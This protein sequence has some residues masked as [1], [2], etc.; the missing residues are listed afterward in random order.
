LTGGRLTLIG[1]AKP[2]GSATAMR[3]FLARH[4]SAEGYAG[5]TDFSVYRLAPSRGHYV[6]GFGR[7]VDLKPAAL[8]ASSTSN[9]RASSST[10]PMHAV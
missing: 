4:P 6:G 9:P 7:I 10:L 2:T 1:E 3:R 8:A 5:F